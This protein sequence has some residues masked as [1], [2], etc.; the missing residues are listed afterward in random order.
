MSRDNRFKWGLGFMGHLFISV[1]FFVG[2]AH[3]GDFA[4]RVKAGKQAL[5]SPEGQQYESSWGEVMQKILTTCIP[6]GSTNPANLG[7][8][9]FIA[10]V[11]ASGLVS[12]VEV[13]PSNTVSRCFAQHFGNA[14]L[15]KPPMT[16]MKGKMLPV[17]DDIEITP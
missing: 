8:F 7:R 4:A 16:L 6:I 1:I 2:I 17:A 9:T 12:S 10:D 5:S 11:S 14:R 3:A 13:E 15:P